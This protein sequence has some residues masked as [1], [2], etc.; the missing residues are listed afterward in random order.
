[1]LNR[2]MIR[3]RFVLL[4][5]ASLT[6]MLIAATQ[7]D[8]SDLEEVLAWIISGGGSG[9]LAGYVIA[10]LLEN[11]SGWHAP[12]FPRWIKVLTPIALTG[13]FA[14]TAQSVM[15]LGGLASVPPFME[16]I[17]L[18][19]INWLFSQKAYRGIKEGVYGD[20]ARHS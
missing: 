5:I 18:W 19:A 15:A 4:L 3:M 6:V 9:V 17:L 13:L 12:T 16:Q 14:F 2:M 7:G 1:M 10:Y 8:F 11:W 20:S